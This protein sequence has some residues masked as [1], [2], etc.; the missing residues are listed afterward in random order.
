MKLRLRHNLIRLRL[1]KSEVE[2]L[3]HGGECREALHFPGGVQLEYAVVSSDI[4]TGI[5]AT[6]GGSIIRV[7]V[8]ARDL[9]RW[10]AS[11]QVSL[12]AEI[13]LS[14][15]APLE[16]LIEKDFRCLDP[17][18]PE[19]QSDTFDNPLARHTVCE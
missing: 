19:D 6:F 14:E 7:D 8:P 3:Q 16:I 17:L 11:D 2:Q 12:S 18:V 5:G 15:G 13:S 10:C 9:A 1:G 4:S